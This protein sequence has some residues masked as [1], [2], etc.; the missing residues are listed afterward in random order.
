MVRR[1][2]VFLLVCLL[3]GALLAPTVSAVFL[4]ANDRLATARV[5]IEGAV[6]KDTAGAAVLI[7]EGGEIL[8]AEGFGYADIAANTLVTPNTVFEIG[9]LSALLVTLS[10]L[11]LVDEG[12]L[13]LEDSLTD[14][15]AND[16]VKALDLKFP[17][18]V[19]QL[20]AGQGGFGGRVMDIS[21]EKEAHCFDTL[22][23]AV[24]AAVPEQVTTPGTVTSY[25]DFGIAL[26]ALVLEFKTG[27]P[28]STYVIDHFLEPLG[29]KDTQ[30]FPKLLIDAPATGYTPGE[31]GLFYTDVHNGRRYAALA[32]ATGAVTSLADMQKLLLWMLSAQGLSAQSRARLGQTVSSGMLTTGAT[33]FIP[34]SN[35]VLALSGSTAC[36]SAALTLDLDAGNAAL[37]LANTPAT[38]LLALPTALF[39]GTALPLTLPQGDMIDLKPLRGIYLPTTADLSSF[40]GRLAAVDAGVSVRVKED[41][42]YFG[43][44]AL[45]QIARGVFADAATPEQPLLQFLLDE[46][47]DV[48]ALVTAEGVSYTAAPAFRTGLPARAALGALLVLGA[49]LLGFAVLGLLRWLADV[50]RK[51]RRDSVLPPMAGVLAALT[52]LLAGAQLLLA[53]KRGAAV[54]SSAYF[55]LRILV[56]LSGIAAMV[57]LV[58][59]FVT[60][61][62]N[63]RTHRHMALTGITFVLFFLLCIFFGLTVM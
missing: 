63:R 1:I 14:H 35:G 3:L 4:P 50:D 12:T 28:F 37:V 44:I 36:F 61:V 38:A 33:P 31:D 57:S 45:M 10:I 17:V 39:G 59:A 15:L 60:T 52:A 13:S 48:A 29:M 42:L 56:L 27:Q 43:D 34:L 2:V 21:Y 51:G 6:G 20:L 7:I 8:M 41:T 9:E 30:C 62:F 49:A 46:N 55:A 5:A 22:T 19:G 25:S 24:L 16:V 23:E 26:L 40:V 47:G 58:L 32:P 53:F 11:R 54:I 18:T